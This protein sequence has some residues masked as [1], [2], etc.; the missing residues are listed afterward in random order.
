MEPLAIVTS[1]DLNTKEYK[2]PPAIVDG[3]LYAGLV[4]FAAP[5]K[6]GK[7]KAA[8]ISETE[9]N[10]KRE[11]EAIRERNTAET[12]RKHGGLPEKDAGA[13]TAGTPEPV[14]PITRMLQEALDKALKGDSDG[15]DNHT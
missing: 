9:S 15:T 14:S 13:D 8:R 3:F 10:R 6:T 7:S 5:A 1:E 2:R 11:K 4:I 12:M